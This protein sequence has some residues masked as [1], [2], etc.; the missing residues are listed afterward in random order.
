[1]TNHASGGGIISADKGNKLE[2]HGNLPASEIPC[3]DAP[4]AANPALANASSV[5]LF[6]IPFTPSIVVT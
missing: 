1:M 2:Q 4:P 6:L 5:A 3:D